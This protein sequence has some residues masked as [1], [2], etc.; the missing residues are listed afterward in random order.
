MRT[1]RFY[2]HMI[3]QKTLLY[4]MQLPVSRDILEAIALWELVAILSS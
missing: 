2:H 4:G 3:F 1:G